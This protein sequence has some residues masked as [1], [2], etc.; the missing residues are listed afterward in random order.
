M[1]SHGLTHANH[2]GKAHLHIDF[3]LCVY[4]FFFLTLLYNC[5]QCVRKASAKVWVLMQFVVEKRAFLMRLCKHKPIALFSGL[6]TCTC[7]LEHSRPC[8][9]IVIVII[10]TRIITLTRLSMH[11]IFFS[12]IFFISCQA[13]NSGSTP[14][15]EHNVMCT[16]PAI[17]TIM[18]YFTAMSLSV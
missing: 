7:S 12:F 18:C 14:V 4:V 10:L 11:L 2:F 16:W 15:R 17:K 1:S 6:K 8:I 3:Y 9:I 13:R 5:L